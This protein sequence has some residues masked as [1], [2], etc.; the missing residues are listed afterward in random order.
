M[1]TN[2][3]TFQEDVECVKSNERYDIHDYKTDKLIISMTVMKPHQETRG[4]DHEDVDEVYICTE[5]EGKMQ[6]G[7]EELD[8]KKGDVITIPLGAFHKVFNPS[9]KELKFLAIFEKYERD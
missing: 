9:D 8:F 7:E 1:K 3:D 6:V 2:I 5:G 4:H